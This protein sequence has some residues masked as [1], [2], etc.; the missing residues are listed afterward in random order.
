MLIK[1]SLLHQSFG[2]FGVCLVCVCVW[3]ACVCVCVHAAELT[4]LPG[5]LR[6]SREGA[7]CLHP[8]ER[9][10]GAYVQQRKP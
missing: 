2:V 9:A 1:T 5:L 6:P 7:L 4:F 3:C 10:P 8:L